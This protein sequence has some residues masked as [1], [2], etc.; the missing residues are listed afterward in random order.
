MIQKQVSRLLSVVVLGLSM[1]VA[2][3]GGSYANADTTTTLPE[4]CSVPVCNIP[5]QVEKLRRMNENQQYNM[6]HALRSYAKS[7]DLAAL[8]NISEFAEKAAI[9][10]KELN[11][12]EW[13]VGEA[14]NVQKESN[15]Q[16]AKYSPL[17]ATVIAGY[18]ARLVGDDPRYDVFKFWRDRIDYFEDKDS[19]LELN[20]LFAKLAEI[21]TRDGNSPYVAGDERA[22]EE[23]I[24]VRIVQLYPY[25][26]G[27]YRISV[28]CEN[29]IPADALPTYC[30][31][32][33]INRLVIMDTLNDDEKL[34][35]ALSNRESGLMLYS[36]SKVVASGGLTTYESV[37]PASGNGIPSQLHLVLDKD[38]GKIEGW[39]RNSDTMITLK[40]EGQ[41][42]STLASIFD[43]QAKSPNREPLTPELI[44]R[45]YRGQYAGRNVTFTVLYFGQDRFGASMAFDDVSSYRLRFQETHFY[46]KLGVMEFVAN[47]TNG[48]HIKLTMFFKTNGTTLNVTGYGFTNF[49]AAVQELT[50]TSATAR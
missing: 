34:Q 17:N 32:N 19:L 35:V 27:T 25:F 13:V 7:T 5:E 21:S 10:L 30:Q 24:T 2:L 41:R 3:S 50:L 40:L 14:L 16:L 36:F 49:G 39:I 6:V 45:S 4:T 20:T 42:E 48:T 47:N 1:G 18:Y 46:P 15:L 31:G 28:H 44:S 23:R 38:T 43:L 29:S 37:S 26:E 9:V 11:A 8:Q 12:V 33:F 22:V